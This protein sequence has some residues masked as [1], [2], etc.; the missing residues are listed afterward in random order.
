[1]VLV[2][3]AMHAPFTAVATVPKPVVAAVTGYALGGGM[4]LALCADFRVCGESAKFGQPEILL[5]AVLL[6]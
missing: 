4:E 2:S 1:M 3:E 5:G 6:L